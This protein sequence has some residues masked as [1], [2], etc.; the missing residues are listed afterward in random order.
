VTPIPINTLSKYVF[1]NKSLI[2]V[3]LLDK[4]NTLVN[5]RSLRYLKRGTQGIVSSKIKSKGIEA[6]KLSIF[7]GSSIKSFLGD[8]RY[9]FNVYSPKRIKQTNKSKY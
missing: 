7:I 2:K 6:M 4:R 9:K 3:S 8:D 1:S 5:L